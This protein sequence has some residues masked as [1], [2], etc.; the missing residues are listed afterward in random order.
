MIAAIRIRGTVHMREEIESTLKLLRLTRANHLVLLPEK[1][2]TISM[3]KK[4][5]DYITWGRISKET[6]RKLLEKRAR[7]PGNKKLTLEYLKKHSI[8]SFGELAE[9]VQAEPKILEK[10]NIKPVF[11]MRPPSKG[12]E[13]GGVK[14]SFVVGGALGYRGEKIND[15]IERM[16]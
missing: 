4:V 6:L 1:E 8:N 13:R 14:K 3:L 15:L 11:R 9:K 16:L 5:K 2:G 12:Y 7:L 10:L